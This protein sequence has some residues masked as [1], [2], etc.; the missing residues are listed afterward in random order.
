MKYI[1][2]FNAS[3]ILEDS[4]ESESDSQEETTNWQCQ[5]CDA[6]I[7]VSLEACIFCDLSKQEGS[8]GRTF[9]LRGGNCSIN[10][11]E[12]TLLSDH[13]FVIRFYIWWHIRSP[14]AQKKISQ[15]L[16]LYMRYLIN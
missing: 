15:A 7:P 2:I 8:Q 1:K 16:Y 11:I 12:Y 5:G 10:F 13:G 9:G 6:L 4:I 3:F 14:L